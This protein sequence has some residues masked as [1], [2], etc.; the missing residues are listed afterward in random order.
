MHCAIIISRFLTLG[1]HV[2][3]KG[4]NCA[5]F[6]TEYNLKNYMINHTNIEAGKHFNVGTRTICWYLK[7]HNLTYYDLKYPNFP[8]EFSD[9]QRETLEGTMLGDAHINKHGGYRF[10]QSIKNK[11]YVE[12]LSLILT[13][14]AR[15]IKTE[16]VPRPNNVN[17]KVIDKSCW[18]GECL[19]CC[20]FDTP[21]HPLFKQLRERWYKNSK[22]TVPSDL[23]LTSRSLAHWFQDDG[24]N[25]PPKKSISLHT[26]GFSLKEITFLRDQLLILGI[27]STTQRKVNR[28]VIAISA[29]SYFDFIELVKPYVITECMKY[30]IDTSQASAAR[31]GWGADKLNFEKAQKIRRL[32]DTDKY[33]QKDLA[34]MYGVS[35]ATIARVINYKIYKEYPKR[36]AHGQADAY[37]NLQYVGS[38]KAW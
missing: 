5:D 30:K 11:G 19:E 22:K 29:R 14:F 33:R 20:Y 35:I 28:H 36:L 27:K 18:N 9:I 7:K 24:S 15:S 10:K 21:C 1:R 38:G 37:L 12:H 3:K 31:P 6:L 26:D 17:G 34:E 32:Y 8:K 2:K 25:N 4:I 23:K 16:K 13:P